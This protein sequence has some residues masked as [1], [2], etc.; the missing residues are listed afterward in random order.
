MFN[1]FRSRDKLIRYL[2]GAML[3][4]VAA[5][6]VT[7]LIPNTG[8][9]NTTDGSDPILADVGTLKVTLAETQAAVDRMVKSGRMP[10]D[11]MESYLPQFVDQ[12]F[13]AH[14]ECLRAWESGSPMKR[15]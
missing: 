2:L 6:M 10:A 9:T 13:R 1:L 7:Y 12:R 15:C 8:Y 11:M 14:C 4:V 5:S 3:L